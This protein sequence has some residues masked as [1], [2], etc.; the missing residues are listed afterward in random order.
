MMVPGVVPASV[1]AVRIVPRIIPSSI[2][3]AAAVPRVIPTTVV[4]RVVPSA[5]VPRVVPAAVPAKTPGRAEVPAPRAEPERQSEPPRGA[6]VHQDHQC[7]PLPVLQVVCGHAL[8]IFPRFGLICLGYEIAVYAVALE[9][10][11]E[12]RRSTASGQQEH[13]CRKKDCSAMI[14][15]HIFLYLCRVVRV[16]F[17]CKNNA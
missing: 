4:P 7:V 12:L 14:H 3:P 2:V 9:S 8:E 15:M 11:G 10:C 6:F 5:A 13:C 17:H 16:S 1:I